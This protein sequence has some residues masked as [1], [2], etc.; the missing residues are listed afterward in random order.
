MKRLLLTAIAVLAPLA[1][2]A[3]DYSFSTT[4]YNSLAH[5]TAYT[6]GLAGTTTTSK[7]YYTSLLND[8]KTSGRVITSATLTVYDIYDWQNNSK[9]PADVLYANI[10]T[11]LNGGYD[12][13]VYD[14]TP[15]TNDTSFG[16]NIFVA[17]TAGNNSTMHTAMPFTNANGNNANGNSL[18]QYTGAHN[19]TSYNGQANPGTWSDPYGGTAARTGY[20][21]G[22]DLVI[23]FTAANLKL[24]ESFL[25]ADSSG[26]NNP[27]VGLGFAAEC[28]YYNSG[29]LLTIT[30]SP[31]PPPSVPDSG[32]TL[33]LLGVAMAAGAAFVRFSKKKSA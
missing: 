18:L 30:T 10:L 4:S 33:I 26:S 9:D 31:T 5:G 25:E 20:A 24:L 21:N 23:N 12:S 11:G 15:A 17:G 29:M 6:W 27:T 8:V 32:N 7:N 1:G 16:P 14:S 22:F 3:T 2:Y 13:Y 19:I 28:H